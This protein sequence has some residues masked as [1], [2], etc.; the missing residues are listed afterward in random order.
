MYGFESH[1]LILRR[2]FFSLSLLFLSY[3]IYSILNIYISHL[4][5]IAAYGDFNVSISLSI[6]LSNFVNLGSVGAVMKFL[7]VYHQQAEDELYSAGFM[8]FY[9]VLSIQ[10]ALVLFVCF[11]LFL[12]M[13]YSLFGRFFEGLHVAY[14]AVLLAPFF[15]LI[16]LMSKLYMSRRLLCW[17]IIP[18]RIL[19]PLIILSFLGVLHWLNYHVSPWRVL[20]LTL[21]ALLLGLWILFF[22][23]FPLTQIRP[24][25]SQVAYERKRWLSVS[26][27]FMLSN[28]FFVLPI[29][30][31]LFLLEYFDVP[32][33]SVGL[34]SAAD[35]AVYL[36]VTISIGLNTVFLPY[37]SEH[38]HHGREATRYA[39][40][41]FFLYSLAFALPFA[42]IFI[43]FSPEIM[44]LWGEDYI[45]GASTL[46]CLSVAYFV[47]VISTCFW[48]AL[49]Y[50]G[51]QAFNVWFNLAKALMVFVFGYYL[52][53]H[54]G[55]L[56]G[57]LGF[58][59]TVSLAGLLSWVV[60]LEKSIISAA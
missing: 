53:P 23:V 4:L 31:T 36:L 56:G 1:S 59:I 5:P 51:F 43:F 3:I 42:V 15:G 27:P 28:F 48:F 26:I 49:Q 38:I 12:L 44:S 41:L 55:A 60:F 35:N 57:A 13:R 24:F 39:I 58:L 20:A 54:L 10:V 50:M 6:L 30:V 46:V 34:F 37:L 29:Q 14:G 21:I 22:F 47:H 33:A 32:E 11:L 19:L 18:E 8:R 25:F 16:F 45:R 9:I 7:P 40:R 17:A 52:I 2:I